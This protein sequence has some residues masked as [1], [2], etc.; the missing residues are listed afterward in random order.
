MKDRVKRLLVLLTVVAACGEGAVSSTTLM[1]TT[2]T[3]TIP[4][5]T[6]AS[7]TTS[8]VPGQLVVVFHG[9]ESPVTCSKVAGYERRVPSDAD[10]IRA[11]FEELLK[12]PSEAEKS[13]GAWSWFSGATAGMLR[14]VSLTGDRL[15]VDFTDF[16]AVIPNASSSC[17][18][19]ALLAQLTATAF[20]FDQV[21]H[22]AYSLEGNCEA[23]GGFLQMG[24][25][26]IARSDWP[27]PEANA[28]E[29]RF[30]AVLPGLAP[31]GPL[32]GS[33]GAAGSAVIFRRVLSLMVCGS[34]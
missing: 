11:A 1:A 33:S 7:P 2:T 13:D 24:C 28:Q 4:I 18:S 29:G 14:D 10:P 23:F 5:A 22:V 17:G 20:Q 27:P 9:I 25:I 32:P 21:N 8:T 30:E 3:T 19:A 6:T 15:T 16:S 12:G 31:P 34:E 26:E